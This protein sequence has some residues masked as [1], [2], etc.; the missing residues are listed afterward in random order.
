MNDTVALAT[1]SQ[2]NTEQVDLIKRTIAKGSTDDELALFVQRQ[3]APDLTH[4]PGRFTPSNAG[5]VAKS[6]R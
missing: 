3:T 5:T 2:L 4:S 1:R 6:A